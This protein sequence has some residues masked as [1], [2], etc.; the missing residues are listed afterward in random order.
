MDNVNFVKNIDNLGRIVIPMDIRRKLD[1]CTGDSI[2][3]SIVDNNVML[4]K[5][6]TLEGNSKII[7]IIKSFVEEFDIKVI[8]MNK[9]KVLYSNIVTNDVNLS[10]ELK[11]A[12]RNGAT[13]RDLVR[14]FIFG[15]ISLKGVYNMLPIVNNEGIVGSIIVISDHNGF[16]FCKLL[17]K[18]ISLELSIS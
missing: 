16:D 7:N 15:D 14:E 13:F 8:Y 11:E 1:L 2:S 5:Y 10:D 6:N 18:I 9:D 12:I 4:T 3:I 17:N